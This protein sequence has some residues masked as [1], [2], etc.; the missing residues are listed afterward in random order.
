M[1]PEQ[2]TVVIDTVADTFWQWP[3]SNRWVS[4]FKHRSMHIV[5]VSEVLALMLLQALKLF[6]SQLL[7]ESSFSLYLTKLM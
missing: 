6:Y 5:L 2:N 1:T 4:K 3:L 7:D